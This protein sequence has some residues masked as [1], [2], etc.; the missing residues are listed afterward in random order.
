MQLLSLTNLSLEKLIEREMFIKVAFVILNLLWLHCCILRGLG[1]ERIVD[2][3]PRG[4]E[5]KPQVKTGS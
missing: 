4:M 2:V 3:V 1:G 5:L